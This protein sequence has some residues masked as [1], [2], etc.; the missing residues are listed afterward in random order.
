MTL[1]GFFFAWMIDRNICIQVALKE[2]WTFLAIS[3]YPNPQCV[4]I[5]IYFFLIL[6]HVLEKTTSTEFSPDIMLFWT[7]TAFPF[8]TTAEFFCCMSLL[9]TM[10]VLFF[11]FHTDEPLSCILMSF[12]PSGGMDVPTCP[13]ISTSFPPPPAQEIVPWSCLS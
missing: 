8:S 9:E 12:Q 3:R 11:A 1:E 6:N 4:Y 10:T 13:T 2:K 7:E 5:Y